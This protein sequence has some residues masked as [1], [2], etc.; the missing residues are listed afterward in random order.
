MEA[1]AGLGRRV[2]AALF[3]YICMQISTQPLASCNQEGVKLALVVR[4]LW[5]FL[6]TEL[7]AASAAL[8]KSML[9]WFD[10][11]R[12]LRLRCMTRN[13]ASLPNKAQWALVGE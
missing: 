12:Y 9:H 2:N 4:I 11:I 6:S 10:T 13:F 8:I 1:K 3:A 5:P 7:L